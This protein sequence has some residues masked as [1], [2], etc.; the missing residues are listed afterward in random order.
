MMIGSDD[1]S[2]KTFRLASTT[3]NC[4]Y[5]SK[6]EP[7]V[8]LRW[9]ERIIS[10]CCRIHP[11][12]GIKQRASVI[13]NEVKGGYNEANDH[14]AAS[15]SFESLLKLLMADSSTG[16]VSK[17]TCLWCQFYACSRWMNK[18]SSLEFHL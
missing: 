11:N 12:L 15:G 6:T 16:R 18:R 17:A 13:S 1:K 10:Y 8:D 5:S 7:A 4:R 2:P 14:G 9:S 3:P